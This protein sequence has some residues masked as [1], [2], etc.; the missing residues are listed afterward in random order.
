MI[1]FKYFND[2]FQS[3][4]L[5]KK[6]VIV[7]GII[8][9]VFILIT[10]YISEKVLEKQIIDN[11]TLIIS[12]LVKT[13]AEEVDKYF[14]SI[15]ILGEQSADII[16]KWISDNKKNNSTAAFNKL[17][18]HN[19]ALRTNLSSYPG[20]DISGVFISKNTEVNKDVKQIIEATEGVFDNYAK[21][22]M[23]FVFNSYLI[24]KSQIIRIYRK[25][26]ALEIEADHDFNNDIFYNIATP[27]NNPSRKPVWTKPYYDAIWKHWMTSLIT[28]VYIK[29]EFIGIVGHDIILDEIYNKILS[30]NY[31][32]SGF[33]FLFDSQKN[34][35]IHP[36]YL[37]RLQ[38]SAEMGT[39]LNSD[40]LENPALTKIIDKIAASPQQNF[41]YSSNTII[42]NERYIFSSKLKILDWFFAI[43]IPE[44]EILKELPSFRHNFYT[45]AM[46]VVIIL[47]TIILFLMFIF[48]IK[49]LR[50][51]IDITQHFKDGEFE[52]KI[53]IKSSD[54][55]GEL[56]QSFNS[57]AEKI[58]DTIDELSSS[59]QKYFGIFSNSIEGIIQTTA[60][61]RF[62]SANPSAALLFGYH[63]PEELMS[64]V[65]NIGKQL[66]VD[67]EDRNRL[68]ALLEDS[69]MIKNYV[70][71]FRKKDGS[72]IYLSS[73]LRCE[74]DKNGKITLIEGFLGDIT[75]KILSEKAL[76]EVENF[77]NVLFNSSKVPIVVMDKESYKYIDCNPAAV[78]I[79]GF[80]RYEDT[81][82]KT[83]L[84]VSPA[85]QYDGVPSAEKAKYYIDTCI[86]TKFIVFEWLHQRPNGE[87]WDAEVHLMLF[88]T[89]FKDLLQF[90]LI[91]ITE[92]KKAERLLIESELK[93]RSIIENMQDVYYRADNKGKLA[94]LSPSGGKLLGYNDSSML[95]G[96]D[97]KETFYFYP[98][99]RDE[100]VKIL[101]E[102]GSVLNYEIT[103]RSIDG[104]PVL[105]STS[106]QL[107]LNENGEYLGVEGTF[108]DIRELKKA[109]E[110][111]RISEQKFE[112]IFTLTPNVIGISRKKDHVIIDGN[113]ALSSY[114]GYTKEEYIGK[115]AIELGFISNQNLDHII[116]KM[117]SEGLLENFETDLTDK[118]GNNKTC[119]ISIKEFRYNDEDCYIFI[120]NDITE[121]KKVQRE[122]EEI[123]EI[124]RLFMENNP[125]YV[126]IKDENIR[127]IF[128]SKNFEQMT[129]MPIENILYKSM[130][131]IFP[132]ELAYKMIEDDKKILR[133][134]KLL[135][136]VEELNGK[137]Y[138]TIK[139]PI[140]INNQPKYLAGYTI[141]IT[142]SK[143]A[144]MALRESEQ[145]FRYLF[146]ASSNPILLIKNDQFI[147]CN[148][149]TLV[150]LGCNNREQVLNITPDIISPEY[151]PNGRKSSE[152]AIEMMEKAYLTG[153]NRFDWTHLKLNGEPFIVEVILVPIVL[154]GEKL[155]HVTWI[156]VTEERRA[157]TELIEA[158][159]KSEMSE[160]LK[161][162]FLAQV[163]HEIRTP[164]N[165]ILSFSNLIK[166]ELQDKI[167]NDLK[168]GFIT[169]HRAGRRIIRTIDL[170][171]NMSELQ[172]GSYDY[173]AKPLDI[174]DEIIIHTFPEY[175]QLAKDKNL[176]LSIKKETD[177][178]VINADEYTVTQIVQ[179]LLDNAIKY[180]NE[181]GIEVI[182]DR[183]LENQLYVSVTDTGVGISEEYLPNLFKAFSQEEQGYTRKFEG[184]GLGLAL[185]KNYCDMN[186]AEI[187]VDSIK[188]VG[189]TF[190]VTF[191]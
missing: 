42:Q 39:I 43:E 45:G 27:Q 152:L 149:A 14:Y 173:V 184:N 143:H 107:L 101:R 10:G 78:E 161:S 4:S 23:P 5:T 28:P 128:L 162:E 188:N 139:F 31:Y 116:Y 181:G 81:V 82:G 83:P 155:L 147:E 56:S 189:S 119:L 150:I 135:E 113:P 169:I 49:P 35:I 174:Y 88:Q 97:I 74:K 132:P 65:T 182:I 123:T 36:F 104:L 153:H 64:E 24:T 34:L 100:F 16:S 90:S 120:V 37:D 151:Q 183:N 62:I 164:I 84:D 33:G 47:F 68:I 125:I 71:Q 178:T 9:I 175:R 15:E 158:K 6:F 18:F 170:I 171:L 11:N 85:F 86:T 108:R 73:T 114:S 17:S 29:D 69:S 50:N 98:D 157:R 32:Q 122:L 129:G 51:I 177:E 59:R 99:Q 180:T 176:T 30:R 61:G 109:E 93:Y 130:D 186:N 165:A 106:S 48:I 148:Q 26:W 159:E 185:I 2:R 13:E 103:L 80:G 60:D 105:V 187:S 137:I 160:R 76:K 89:E 142:D 12:D 58:R 22:L 121:R 75:E 163:S 57:M 55:F 133:E 144:E 140:I 191:R 38:N 87:F 172:S 126:F 79:Y 115:T 63:S 52:H 91:D 127:A 1:S 21:A 145:T 124:F 66:Y 167:D 44:E 190:K 8:F 154:K 96:L 166:E 19:G 77:K 95:I 134:G 41:N 7:T 46:F 25:D 131:E 94:I 54:E 156:D 111:L 92:R 118:F 168:D 146:E 3:T 70:S 117:S 102:R 179:N 110:K 141:D 67:I 40:S 138:H 20:S 53:K 72:I 136:V 112:E